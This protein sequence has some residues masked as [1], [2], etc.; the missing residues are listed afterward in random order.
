MLVKKLKKREARLTEEDKAIRAIK[1]KK[2]PYAKG[3]F[4]N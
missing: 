1:N 3:K 4:K 2:Y